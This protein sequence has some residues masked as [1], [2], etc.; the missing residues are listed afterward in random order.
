ML[1]TYKQEAVV[2]KKQKNTSFERE[3]KTN[4]SLSPASKSRLKD[5]TG[6]D[7]LENPG[8]GLPF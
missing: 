6:G 7:G 1:L 3:R 4:Q 2:M 5:K 8:A